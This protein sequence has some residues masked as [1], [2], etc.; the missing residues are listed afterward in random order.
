[1]P[2]REAGLREVNGNHRKSGG[3][4]HIEP[5]PTVRAARADTGKRY[6]VFVTTLEHR[7][8]KGLKLR[9]EMP[10]DGLSLRRSDERS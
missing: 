1:M 8:A 10:K 6:D 4:I 2:L 9:H 5:E 7:A 3:V